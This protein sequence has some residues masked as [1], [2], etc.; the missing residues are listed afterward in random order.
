MFFTLI[1]HS[2]YTCWLTAAPAN[3]VLELAPRLAL[4]EAMFP[5]K[6]EETGQTGT[7]EMEG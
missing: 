6:M 5:E 3:Q 2:G 4:K 7:G 1:S